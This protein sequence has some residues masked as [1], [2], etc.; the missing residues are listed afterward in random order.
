MDHFAVTTPKQCRDHIIIQNTNGRH[1]AGP[2]AGFYGWNAKNSAFSRLITHNT[3]FS[4][5]CG[6]F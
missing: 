2:H 1:D 3:I 6:P 4:K 5:G